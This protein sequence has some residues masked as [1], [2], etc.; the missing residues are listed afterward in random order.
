MF[1]ESSNVVI[2]CW[3]ETGKSSNNNFDLYNGDIIGISWDGGFW[4]SG[5]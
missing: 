1:S 2:F 5:C 3:R 4:K